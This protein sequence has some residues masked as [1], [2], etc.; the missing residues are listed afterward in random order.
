MVSAIKKV[1]SCFLLPLILVQYTPL[2]GFASCPGS[3]KMRM[4]AQKEGGCCSS[5]SHSPGKVD[6]SR[7]CCCC[8]S[9]SAGTTG[10]DAAAASL[11][12]TNKTQQSGLQV[13]P[14]EDAFRLTAPELDLLSAP[15]SRDFSIAGRTLHD[16]IC[17]YLC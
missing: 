17:S 2:V 8:F 12:E 9:G 7:N 10:T 5:A 4:Q 15:L 6:I 14:V 16:R 11:V 13:F 3:G 1:I